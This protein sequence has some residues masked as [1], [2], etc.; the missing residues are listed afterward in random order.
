MNLPSFDNVEPFD[1]SPL[2]NPAQGP[3]KAGNLAPE[4]VTLADDKPD[5]GPQIVSARD[6][7]AV[8][9]VEPPQVVHG[10]LRAGQVGLLAST[11]KAGKTW[12]TQK[13]ALAVP[14]GR[15]WLAWK[16]TP[17]RVL[18]VDPELPPYDGQARLATLAKAMG[19][20]GVPDGLDLWR[21]KGTTMGIRDMI[22]K[23]LRRQ[24]QNG[25]PYTLILLDSLYCLNG[26]RDECDNTEQAKTMQEL[27]ALTAKTG[28]AAL[29]THH[30]SKGN[31]AQTDH[32]DRASGAGVF[33]RAPDVFMTLTSHKE[34]NCYSVETT[35]RSFAKPRGFVVRWEYPLW[36]IAHDLNPDELKRHSG[37]GRAALYTPDQMVD[38]LPS[39]G[40]THGEWC[41]TA[42]DSL[43]IKKSAFNTM[44]G[45][46]KAEKLVVLAFGK[47]IP[48]SGGFEAGL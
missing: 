36:R 31:K 5:E 21:V 43:G 33:A 42:D 6:F 22:P 9:I 1:K 32:L 10:V 15:D 28:A 14:N 34:E 7:M 27:Y 30:F 3:F 19:L 20:D 26:G 8:P 23:I 44:L 2:Y 39:E 47:Y 13:L 24:E 17:G 38:L 45:R 48:N 25:E 12:L 37:A 11:S 41:K 35:C 18:F 46:A 4:A 40:L 29:V 16:T